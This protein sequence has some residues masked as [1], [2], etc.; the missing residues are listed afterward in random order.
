MGQIPE[1]TRIEI[2]KAEKEAREIKESR[3]RKPWGK[4]STTPE[5]VAQ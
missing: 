5:D 4:A 3:A 1:A 2:E